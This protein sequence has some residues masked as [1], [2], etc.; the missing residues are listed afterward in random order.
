MAI[1]GAADGPTSIIVADSL[2]NDILLLLLVA[3]ILIGITV[4][5]KTKKKK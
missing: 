4:L 2:I 1:I 3:I 5:I